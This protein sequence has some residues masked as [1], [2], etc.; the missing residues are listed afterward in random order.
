MNNW[1]IL[2]EDN[3]S[4]DFIYENLKFNPYSKE[5]KIISKLKK[6][7]I[8]LRKYFNELEDEQFYEK[9][10]NAALETLKSMV[11]KNESIIALN[12]QHDSFSFNPNLNFELDEFGDWLVPIFPNG[13][14]TFFLT[15][16]FEN[17][18]FCNGIDLEISFF[19]ERLQS[20]DLVNFLT[21]S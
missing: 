16:N 12:W 4:W 13:D 14:Y 5:E 10:N 15:N 2:N 7:T 18:I 11:N 1:Q 21:S 3:T 8:S 17:I 6:T 19:G 9:F 20:C